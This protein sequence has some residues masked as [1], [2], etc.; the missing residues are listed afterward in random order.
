MH[1]SMQSCGVCLSDCPSV[2]FMYS[3]ERNKPIFKTF[4]PSGSHTI[5][6][7]FQIKCYGNIP[8]RTPITGASNAGGVWKISICD[9]YLAS[10]RVVNIA[11][12]RCYK[13]HGPDHGK[14]VTIIAFS[15][16]G[17]VCWS[18]RRSVYNN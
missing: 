7:F 1:Y 13:H 5:L 18:R 12:A 8:T 14:L 4:S 3:V 17:G 2:M 11:T 6:V 10:S 16:S 15:S 9:R